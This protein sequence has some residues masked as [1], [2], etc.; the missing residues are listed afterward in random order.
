MV[1]ISFY[2][3]LF[4]LGSYIPSLTAYYGLCLSIAILQGMCDRALVLSAQSWKS[5]K[6]INVYGRW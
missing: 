4:P 2:L 5:R 6:T 1:H 3:N